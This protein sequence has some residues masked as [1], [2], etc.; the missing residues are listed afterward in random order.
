MIYCAIYAEVVLIWYCFGFLCYECFCFLL[1][2][3]ST[4]KLTE[5]PIDKYIILSYTL[6]YKV[7]EVYT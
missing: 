3:K 2:L 5:L 6:Y 4:V 1:L 7:Y